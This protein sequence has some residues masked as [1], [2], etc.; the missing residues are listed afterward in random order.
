VKRVSR[1]DRAG[2][3]GRLAA[4]LPHRFRETVRVGYFDEE[5]CA[6]DVVRELPAGVSR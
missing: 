2:D 1:Q 4:C 3:L 5:R 6:S